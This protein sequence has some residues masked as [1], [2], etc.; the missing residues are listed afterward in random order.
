M[1]KLFHLA[2]FKKQLAAL[3]IGDQACPPAIPLV[4]GLHL[5]TETGIVFFEDSLRIPAFPLSYPFIASISWRFITLAWWLMD[6]WWMALSTTVTNSSLR[7]LIRPLM[8]ARSRIS[9]QRLA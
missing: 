4:S 1:H 7:P 5:I 8:M 9:L 6:S 2:V 3:H